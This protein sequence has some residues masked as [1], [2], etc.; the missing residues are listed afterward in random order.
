MPNRARCHRRY[1]SC[2]S[3][4]DLAGRGGNLH[5]D[6][7]ARKPESP[8]KSE[9]CNGGNSNQGNGLHL[10]RHFWSGRDCRWSQVWQRYPSGT[11][12][13]L[14]NRKSR[15]DNDPAVGNPLHHLVVEPGVGH[16]RKSQSVPNTHTDAGAYT[17]C[18][19][20]PD[21]QPNTGFFSDTNTHT[22]ASPYTDCDAEPDAHP[23]TIAY[24]DPNPNTS[25]FSDTNADACAN[26]DSNPNGHTSPKSDA[27]SKANSSTRNLDIGANRRSTWLRYPNRSLRWEHAG[28]I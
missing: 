1:R 17:D 15:R 16:Y 10:K 20:E 4:A 2:R 21:A 28:E 13:Q 8:D 11:V 7:F 23:N 3:N 14:F 9:L 18:D 22:H 26:R 27:D 25:N 19:A 12:E 5:G 24:S 6:D